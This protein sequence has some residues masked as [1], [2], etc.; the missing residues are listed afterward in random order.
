MFEIIAGQRRTTDQAVAVQCDQAGPVAIALA[1]GKFTLPL[2]QRL[3]GVFVLKLLVDP[4]G[5]GVAVLHV[6]GEPFELHGHD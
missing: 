1:L 4:R 3:M 2:S 6:A 5:I